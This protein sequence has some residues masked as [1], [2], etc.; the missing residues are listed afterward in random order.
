MNTG[1]THNSQ[2]RRVYQ[3]LHNETAFLFVRSSFEQSYSD[4][5]K[6]HER[7]AKSMIHRAFSI[8]LK[9]SE[10]RLKKTT[11]SINREIFG[12][13]DPLFWFNRMYFSYKRE[14]R[15]K[16]DIERI[17]SFLNGKSIL[18]FGCGAGF[19]ALE[20]EGLGYEILTTDV[21]QYRIPEA[22]HLEFRQM[23][24]A[25]HVPFPDKSVDIT[26]A[27]TVLHHI[28]KDDQIALL[29]QLRRV[30]RKRLLLEE[31]TYSLPLSL[32]GLEDVVSTQPLLKKFMAMSKKDQF[33]SLI[34]KDYFANA[35]VFGHWDINFPFEFKTITEWK[36]I[37]KKTNFNLTKVLIE[38]FPKDKL[39]SNCQVWMVCDVV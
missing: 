24:D 1:V 34:L 11:Q 18:D 13:D 36:N 2:L 8:L 4:Y 31:D 7:E 26:I 9:S 17:H 27:K 39:T 5:F 21:L 3:A 16:K 37:L 23:S 19:L 25:T 30:T 29:A 35:V 14:L 12:K 33:D 38:G 22:Q 32:E 15:P 10:Q 28:E 6:H 20:L